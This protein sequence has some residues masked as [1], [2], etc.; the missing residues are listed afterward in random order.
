[1]ILTLCFGDHLMDVE[2]FLRKSSTA[3]IRFRIS[4][5]GYLSLSS[6]H[7]DSNAMTEL[8]LSRDQVIR[9]INEIDGVRCVIEI[10]DS[11]TVT[12]LIGG[13]IVLSCPKSHSIF[14]PGKTLQSVKQML[15]ALI[16]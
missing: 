13:S 3:S 12:W 16:N 9:L 8:I 14:I 11:L 2:Y 1:M 6:V 15:I 7:D 10:G 5:D 4:P